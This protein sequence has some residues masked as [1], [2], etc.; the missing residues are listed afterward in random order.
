[1]VY[2]CRLGI[3]KNEADTINSHQIHLKLGSAISVL[4]QKDSLF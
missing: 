2:R 3:I 4:K 1:M